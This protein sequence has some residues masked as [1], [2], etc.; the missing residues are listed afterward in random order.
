MLLH[1]AFLVLAENSARF[2]ILHSYIL[3]QVAC[4]YALLFNNFV[5]LPALQIPRREKTIFASKKQSIS[6]SPWIQVVI[7]ICTLK[8]IGT[9]ERWKNIFM[10]GIAVSST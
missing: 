6:S 1:C 9:G 2:Q 3:T 4:S 5:T 8:G 7:I 10:T